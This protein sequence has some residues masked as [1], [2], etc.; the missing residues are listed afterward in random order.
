MHRSTSYY[1]HSHPVPYGGGSGQQSVTAY[2]LANDPNSLWTIVG[3]SES[4]P[5][6]RGATFKQGDRLR[7]MHVNT[8]RNLHT[9]PF[10][11]PLSGQQEVSAYGEDGYGDDG[12]IWEVQLLKSKVWKRGESVRLFHSVTRKF[13]HSH[14]S[15]RFMGNAVGGQQEVTAFP[16]KN[17]EN[18]WYAEDGLYMSPLSGEKSSDQ[19]AALADI[20]QDLDYPTNGA[21]GSEHDEL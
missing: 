13:L 15:H 7:L 3:A 1:L 4:E 2:P 10:P 5:C 21:G 16:N 14:A 9:H 18:V 20:V 19:G 17:S 11:S 12:D 8:R 6:K